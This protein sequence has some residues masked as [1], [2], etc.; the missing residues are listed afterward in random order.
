[1]IS[2]SDDGRDDPQTLV[3]LAILGAAEHIDTGHGE[4]ATIRSNYLARFPQSAPLFGFGNF[5]LWRIIPKSARFVAGFAK[6]YNL[7]PNALKR[8][9]KG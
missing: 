6:T 2:E 4:Y 3:R 5:W 1:M 7:T 8:I 9:S